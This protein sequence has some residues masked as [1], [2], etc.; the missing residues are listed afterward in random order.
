MPGAGRR[1]KL[2]R[3]LENAD[4]VELARRLAELREEHRDLDTA[5]ERLVADPLADQ[6]TVLRLKKRKLWLK[7]WIARIES[8]LI[9]DQPA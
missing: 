2:R 3:M 5:I 8:A 7:D 9:P 4:P 1:A 6:L